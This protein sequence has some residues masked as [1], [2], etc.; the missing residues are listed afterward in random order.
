M[1]SEIPL[2]IVRTQI[3]PKCSGQQLR[4]LRGTSKTLRA[5]VDTHDRW[6]EDVRQ[7]S[8]LPL[9]ELPRTLP[10]LKTFAH[11]LS[12]IGSCRPITV[13]DFICREA[14]D[15]AMRWHHT[16]ARQ[17]VWESNALRELEAWRSDAPAGRQQAYDTAAQR[18]CAVLRTHS[19]DAP[20]AA[21]LA[22]LDLSNLGLDSVP[23]QLGNCKEVKRLNMD[24]NHLRALPASCNELGQLA[25]LSI[26]NNPHL[27]SLPD[28]I[29]GAA[30]RVLN[31]SGSGLTAL[32]RL[33][34][35]RR[36]MGLLSVDGI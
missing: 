12:L 20:P 36:A 16:E 31:A 11:G 13:D 9:A 22:Q 27:T 32:P 3:V 35:Q 15:Q 33:W 10:E 4:T 28:R 23:A 30:L 7:R 26:Q 5:E 1:L 14:V 34:E 25:S 6:L 29:G 8:R 24:G 19:A 17:A 18:I 21:N 2:D